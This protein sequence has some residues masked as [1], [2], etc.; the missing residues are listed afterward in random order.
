MSDP[1]SVLGDRTQAPPFGVAGGGSAQ[2][3]VVEFTTGGKSWRPEFGGKQEK[4]PL[5]AGDAI[6][7]ASPGGGG[8]GPAIERELDAVEAD[9]NLGYISRATAERDYAVVIAE[10]REIGGRT[11]YKIDSLA[12][13]AK[14]AQRTTG[15]TIEEARVR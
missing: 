12:S 9:L 13:A 2:P 10:A 14:R 6:R 8:F 15:K 3:S 7:A 4:Q 11:R 1:V 5:A